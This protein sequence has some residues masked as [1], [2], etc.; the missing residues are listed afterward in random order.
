M[1]LR[2]PPKQNWPKRKVKL[3]QFVTWLF[4]LFQVLCW[5]S[6]VTK[7][8]IFPPRSTKHLLPSIV[9]ISFH[10]LNIGEYFHISISIITYSECI[11]LRGCRLFCNS[12][13]K[14]RT[15]HSIR[16][17]VIEKYYI[18]SLYG[19]LSIRVTR[20]DNGGRD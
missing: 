5:V 13:L 8:I 14:F 20:C 4:G 12:R 9:W 1:G 18:S 7:L 16:N 10:I 15:I 19:A 6:D 17:V 11:R 3:Y 2:L